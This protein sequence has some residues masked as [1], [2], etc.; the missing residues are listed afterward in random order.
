VTGVI[1]LPLRLDWSERTE[2]HVDDPAERNVLYERVIREATRVD[3][4]RSYRNE[5]VL[6]QVR[7]MDPFHERLARCRSGIGSGRL[8]CRAGSRYCGR[9]EPGQMLWD[10]RGVS[11]SPHRLRPGWGN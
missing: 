7:G 3:D 4:M 6:R 9:D 10:A 8:K 11:E 1:R 2:F 5:Q